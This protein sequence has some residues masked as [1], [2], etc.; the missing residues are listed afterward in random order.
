MTAQLLFAHF[1]LRLTASASDSG[2]S[3]RQF[4]RAA[5]RI[6]SMQY[7]E[8][9]QYDDQTQRYA[10]NPED[11]SSTHSLLLYFPYGRSSVWQTPR[12]P[13]ALLSDS[14]DGTVSTHDRATGTDQK[15]SARRRGRCDS[16][17]TPARVSNR[18]ITMISKRPLT[19]LGV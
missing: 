17:G 7:T 9:V 15:R 18:M 3:F 6:G 11:Q 19:P 2:I 5:I 1:I 12:P 8:D 4:A 14:V 16:Q 13:I 10:E